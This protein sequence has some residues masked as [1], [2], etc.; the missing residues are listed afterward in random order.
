VRVLG[1]VL[2][3][4]AVVGAVATGAPAAEDAQEPARATPQELAGWKHY[5]RLC[6][7]CHGVEGD[8]RGPAT[9]WVWPP[10]RDLRTGEHKWSSAPV[11]DAALD[12]DLADTIRWGVPGTSM[13]GFGVALD[14]AAIAELVAVVRAFAPPATP[15]KAA[16]VPAT[17]AGDVDR[18]AKLWTKAGCTSCHGDAGTVKPRP[19]DLT[20]LQ[21]RRPRAE[22]DDA[23]RALYQ[24]IALGLTGTAMPGYASLGD[25][26]LADLVAYVDSIRA[27]PDAPRGPGPIPPPAV[28]RDT[29]SGRT[30][31]GHWAGNDPAEAV[32]FGGDL[33]PQGEP[34]DSL[35]PAQASLSAK[36][37]G[38]CHAKQLEAW[39]GSIHAM[40]SSPGLLGQL[41]RMDDEDEKTSCRRCH[42][43]LA[44]QRTDAQLEEEGLNCAACHVRGWTRHGP[45]TIAGDLEPLPNYPTQGLAIYERSDFC[46]PCHQLPARNE[47]AGRPLLDTYREW[48]AGPYM[49]RGIQCQHCHMPERAHTWKG[50]HDPDTFRQ[51]IRVEVI[52]A[53]GKSG[54]VSVRARLWND[55]AGHM[56]PTTPT[57]AAWLEIT[58]VDGDGDRIK[59]AHA[60]Q[61]IGRNLT[62]KDDAWVELEDTR[63]P[64][65][66]SIELAKAW[67]RG[68][69]DEATH[70]KVVV[71]VAPDEYYER[72]YASRLDQD[73]TAEV[74][75]QFEAALKRAKGNR[76]VAE[77]LLIAIE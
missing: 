40:A 46:M 58:L 44:E 20:Q 5:D 63:V 18:G 54:V 30:R 7:P 37:C 39:T 6:L 66:E 12:A 69:V 26:A 29:G 60:S 49:P 45:T 35:A 28:E 22:V 76:Y 61:R 70:A 71:R 43:P 38:R 42:A 17:I 64:P 47:V 3:C 55:G 53:R 8:G 72:L 41:A 16:P 1:S 11:G 27:R 21:F 52:A 15:G 4:V 32:V 25:A 68:R 74:R 65:G 9:P 59:G 50:I 62:S 67:K 75:T 19:Y 34:P 77:T 31:G 36:R 73:L 33:A 13:P 23:Q 51:G 14:D 48:L 56:L 24:S 10:P 2:V 57:P